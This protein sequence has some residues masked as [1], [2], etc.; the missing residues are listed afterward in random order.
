MIIGMPVPLQ[1]IQLLWLNL[2]TDGLPALALGMEKAEPGIMNRPP[3]PKTEPIMN[4]E[5]TI[6]IAVQGI[7]IMVATLG[8]FKIGLQRNDSYV[9]AQ[10]MAV[11]TLV[12][13]ELLRA[14]TARSE[15]YSIFT[16]G[17][18]S[19]KYMVGATALSALLIIIPL[20]APFLHPIFDVVTPDTQD[21]MVIL[22]FALIPSIVAEITKIFLRAFSPSFKQKVSDQ[23]K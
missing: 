11:A 7:A 23:G 22:S 2:L 17:F 19:N 20:Y 9:E 1:P 16:L 13:S 3:R 12:C 6:G 15:F 4:K 14:Y 10:T 21:W 5:M 8:A 18:W